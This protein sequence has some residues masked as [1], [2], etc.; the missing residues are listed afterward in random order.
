MRLLAVIPARAGSKR[1]PGKNTR[2][3]HG[4]P[5]LGWP[6]ATARES[7]LFARVMVSTED[8]TVAALAREQGAEA[9]FLRDPATADDR[10]GLTEV[11]GEV[12]EAFE[13]RG[14]QFDA[15]CCLLATAALITPA[16]LR[17]GLELLR[18]GDWAGAYPVLPYAPPIQR[19]LIR[20]GNGATKLE[21]PAEAETRTQDLP[22]RYHD[23]GQ[24]YWLTPEAC[25]ARRSILSGHA[26]TLVLGE[27]E[28]QDVDSED[29]W[30]LAEMKFA[31]MRGA[32]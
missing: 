5:M 1:V 17:E 15:V 16:R 22:A 18:S 19:A 2:L 24:F 9:P 30:K 29:D 3:F 11:L 8:E 27:M 14:E 20:A 12:V 4:R 10:A 31:L 23:A 21:N 6:I 28:A 26:A 25:R 32:A 13:A 7:G